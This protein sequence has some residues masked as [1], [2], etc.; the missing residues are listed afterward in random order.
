MRPTGTTMHPVAC[1][2]IDG[3]FRQENVKVGRRQAPDCQSGGYLPAAS[4][5]ISAAESA[6]A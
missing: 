4:A 5:L 3:I 2:Y 1:A 6:R